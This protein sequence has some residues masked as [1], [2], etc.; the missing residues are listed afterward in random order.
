MYGVG[1]VCAIKRHEGY[2]KILIEKTNSF[3]KNRGRIGLLFCRQPLLKFYIQLGWKPN[4][5]IY[6]SGFQ[7]KEEVK[8][9][10]FNM[11][12]TDCTIEYSGQMF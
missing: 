12:N 4:N 1:N 3:I 11:D 6:F 5:R 9:L 2:G 7:V 10:T 8:A